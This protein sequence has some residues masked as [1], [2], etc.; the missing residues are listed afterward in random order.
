MEYVRHHFF[1]MGGKNEVQVYALTAD[2]AQQACMTVQAEVQRIEAKYSRYQP[3]S[4][5]SLINAAAG[6]AAA[7]LDAETAALLGYADVCFRASGGLFDITSGVLRKAWDFSAQAGKQQLPKPEVLAQLLQRVG[8]QHVRFDAEQV[9]LPQGMEIDFGGIGKEYAAD[10]AAAILSAQG[11]HHALVNLA[12]DVRV[13]GPQP[14]PQ[15][16][17]KDGIAL[18]TMPWRIGI[19]HP[20]RAGD[21]LCMVAM[22]QGA[23]ATSGDYERFIE[24][25]GRRYCHIL[26]PRTGMPVAHWQ[27][28]SVIA[29]LCLAAGSASTISMLKGADARNFL[30]AQM[31][32]YFVTDGKNRYFQGIFSQNSGL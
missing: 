22:D 7:K 28:V 20:R 4:A 29:P 12:G 14:V 31:L 23:L 24:I 13:L 18:D 19:T 26:N 2:A 27:S 8:W 16:A 11:I 6:K 32:S 21:T 17:C 30:D 3:H 9:S 25:D 5:L 1:A 15:S 10:R